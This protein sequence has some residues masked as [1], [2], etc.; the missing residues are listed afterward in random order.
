MSE[1][2]KKNYFRVSERKEKILN[3]RKKNLER[4]F[5]IG[6]YSA[7]EYINLK[8]GTTSYIYAFPFSGKTS[9]LFNI[10][11]YIAKRYGTK[12]AIYSPETGSDSALVTFLVQVY[13]GKK[14]HGR[15]G[16]EATDA[17]WLEALD[18]I[19]NHFVILDPVLIGVNKITFSAK[20]MFKQVTIAEREYGW[21]V[22]IVVV[23]P[24]NLLARGEGEKSKPISEYTLENLSYINQVAEVLDKHIM[25]AMHLRDEEPIVDKESGEEYMPKPY[26]NKIHNGQSVWRAGQLMMGMWRTPTGAIEKST[27]IPYEPYRTDFFVQKNK[28]L[29]AGEV[30]F[31]TLYYDVPSQRFYEIVDGVRYFCGEYEQRAIKQVKKSALKPNLNFDSSDEII[32]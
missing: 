21:N 1:T 22:E 2:F 25:I 8:K 26:P 28:M 30:G 32:F 12:I 14:L 16:Q 10:L 17:E 20:E 27:G 5:E 31:F 7:H 3:D 4:G 29:G 11:M 19:D 18:F 9:W 6:Y 23:D 24:Y 13:L 15:D